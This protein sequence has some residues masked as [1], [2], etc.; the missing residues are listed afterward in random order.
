MC[1]IDLYQVLSTLTDATLPEGDGRSVILN[2][3]IESIRS[4]PCPEGHSF[5]FDTALVSSTSLLLK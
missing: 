3:D 2:K 5:L 4:F 1:K